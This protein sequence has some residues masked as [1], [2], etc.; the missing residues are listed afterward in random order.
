MHEGLVPDISLGTH[1][2]NDL[3]EMD[4]LYLAIYPQQSGSLYR[5]DFFEQAPN[6]LTDIF[7]DAGNWAHVVRVIDRNWQETPS[8]SVHMDTVKQ[9]GFCYWEQPAVH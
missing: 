6:R 5:A 4:M 7:P 3:V 2:F 9:E 8:L 1:F